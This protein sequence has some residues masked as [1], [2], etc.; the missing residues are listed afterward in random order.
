[1]CHR[2]QDVLKYEIQDSLLPL[3]ITHFQ[4]LV[5]KCRE[6]EA[7]KNCMRNR[8]GTSNHGGPTR[9]SNQNQGRSRP[10]QKPYD[11]PQGS[12]KGPYRPMTSIS[13]DRRMTSESKPY[14]YHCGDPRH[15]ADKCTLNDS[16]C[17][18]CQKPEHLARDFKEPKAEALL[19]ATKV[20]RPT[21]QGRVYNI[22]GQG[23]SCPNESFQGECEI[24]SNILTVLFNS[25]A[26]HS[27]ISMD[28]VKLLE[29][30]VTTLLFDLFVTTAADKTL[31]ANTAC[32]HCPIVVLSRKFNV[33]LICLAL[34]N[35]DVIFG[36]DWL[37]YHYI[38]LDCGRKTVI[39][40]DP[41]LS[42]FLAAHE[43]KV[44]LKE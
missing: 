5:E 8:G 2:F 12:N 4:P 36:M 16:V 9:P 23:T 3:G 10:N 20:T 32:M 24:S 26:T 18:K 27:F 14:C 38:L 15:F 7:M 22:N 34:K 40:P 21:T 17:F 33:N 35:L 11:R 19:K 28:C 39:F 29:L 41:E 42:K 25:D 13:D 6:V 30:H 31:T 37:S 1:M 43:I 44:A